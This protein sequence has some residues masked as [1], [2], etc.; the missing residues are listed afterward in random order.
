M[1]KTSDDMRTQDKMEV[2][3]QVMKAAQK[4]SQNTS[5]NHFIPI[6]HYAL[7]LPELTFA[8]N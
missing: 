6:Q 1:D 4:W 5:L 3:K 2:V 7:H 8:H